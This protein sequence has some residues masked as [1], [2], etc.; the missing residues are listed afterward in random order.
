MN[1][2]D[3]RPTLTLPKKY[4]SSR[5]GS[6]ESAVQTV[7]IDAVSGHIFKP[8]IVMLGFSMAFAIPFSLFAIFPSWLE[9]LP[10]SGGWLNSVKIILGYL[11]LALCIKFLSMP[12]QAYHWGIL[13]RKV[14]FSKTSLTL[15]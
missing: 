13:N 6:L 15:N 8:I 3:A 1:P 11:E 5:D 2:N 4:L 7:M 10:K 12:D 9:N 14:F